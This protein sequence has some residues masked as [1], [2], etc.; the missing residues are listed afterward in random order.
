[1]VLLHINFRKLLNT[2]LNK[3]FQHLS[4][5]PQYHLY[6]WLACFVVF[7]SLYAIKSNIGEAVLRI[8][9]IGGFVTFIFYFNLFF[10]IPKYLTNRKPW[11]YIIV[12]ILFLIVITYLRYLTDRYWLGENLFISQKPLTQWEKTIYTYWSMDNFV[13]YMSLILSLNYKWITERNKVADAIKEK[14]RTEIK[15]LYHQINP[16]FLLNTLNNIYSLSYT[17]NALA[18]EMILKLS[19]SMKYILYECEADLVS[20]DAEIQFIESYIELNKLKLEEPDK[21]IWTVTGDTK[22]YNIAPMLLIP[23]IENAFK[24]GDLEH[25]PNSSIEFSINIDDA[26]LLFFKSRNH[27][28]PTPKFYEKSGIGLKNVQSRLKLLYPEKHKLEI[29]NYNQ[30]YT[31]ELFISLK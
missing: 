26:G 3:K 7:T 20:L 17:G 16:H 31:I 15:F 9:V 11:V 6:F 4:I 29:K 25:L 19:E 27:I 2:P 8:L 1:M 24:Y 18:T 10:L 5:K 30:I 23:F 13:Y 21:I 22:S 28:R 14:A 12:T